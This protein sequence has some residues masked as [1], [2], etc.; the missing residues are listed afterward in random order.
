MPNTSQ[1][2][3]IPA[4]EHEAAAAL[5]RA[6]GWI[7]TPPSEVRYGCFCDLF[8]CPT[9]TEPDGCVIDD[10]CRSACIYAARHERKEECEY[11]K[12]WT[13]ETLATYWKEMASDD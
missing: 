5:L 3:T 4:P 11:W 6:A 1:Q 13:A 7:V 12:P 8:A 2:T 9:G 10:D